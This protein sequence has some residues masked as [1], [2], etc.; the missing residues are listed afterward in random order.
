MSV[1]RV[2]L[3]VMAVVGG[4]IGVVLVIMPESREFSIPPYFWVLIAMA[5]FESLAF[6][7][8]GGRPG[9]TVT[10]QGRLIAFIVSL[11]LVVMIPV[12]AGSPARLL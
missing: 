2:F 1:D 3:I 11:V 7:R 8:G 6:A 5:L 12:L 4:A 10:M 9:T